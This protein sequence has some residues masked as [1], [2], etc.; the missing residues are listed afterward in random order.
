VFEAFG[1]PMVYFH[2]WPDVTI[3]TSKDVPDNLDATKLG[4]VAYMTAG[5]AWTLAALP[6]AEAAR[7][8]AL[9]HAATDERRGVA[10]YQALA[11]GW[12]SDDARLAAREAVAMGIQGLGTIAAMWPGTAA[13][14][15]RSSAALARSLTTADRAAGAGARD[16]RVPERT[17]A[18]Q[19]PLDVYYYD[20]LTAVLGDAAGT[21][22]ALG[23]RS[24]VLTY[25]ALNLID[26]RRSVGQIRDLL[27]G[28]YL[29]VPVSEVSEWL[30]LLARAG[31]VRFKQPGVPT[32]VRRRGVE[33]R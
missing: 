1:V 4:R 2:D 3:H 33:P 18:V 10:R 6:E 23:R 29:P 13:E 20:H 17:T 31:V 24:E 28:R 25:E 21:P 30:D 14:V 16:S 5:I 7:L 22:P 12:S 15:G 27:A 11:A 32:P 9:E 8:P 26:G 19:G